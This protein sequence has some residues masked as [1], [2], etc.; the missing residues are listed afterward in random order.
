MGRI[1]DLR[2]MIVSL[3]G[4]R[5]V[6]RVKRDK[7]LRDEMNSKSL[8]ELRFERDKL[9]LQRDGD[10]E[11]ELQERH[12]ARQEAKAQAVKDAAV[13]LLDEHSFDELVGLREAAREAM[14]G[15]KMEY[16]QLSRAVQFHEAKRRVDEKIASLSPEDR[17][18]W[19][20]LRSA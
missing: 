6:P 11:A 10:N 4:D 2:D 20:K 8:E 17:E 15:T 12:E 16:E 5:V 14:L 19:D 13:K 9:K 1:E 7:A 18:A 3:D